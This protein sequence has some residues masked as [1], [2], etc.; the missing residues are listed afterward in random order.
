MKQTN[1]SRQTVARR[2]AV[3]AATLCF[4]WLASG[5]PLYQSF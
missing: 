4:F 2:L 5:A 3:F 1:P